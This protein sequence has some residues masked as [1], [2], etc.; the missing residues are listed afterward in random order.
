MARK[1]LSR[2]AG[3]VLRPTARTERYMKTSTVLAIFGVP[4]LFGVACVSVSDEDTALARRPAPFNLTD[5][6][7]TLDAD[8]QNYQWLSPKYDKGIYASSADTAPFKGNP[9]T[10]QNMAP[11][12]EKTSK[13]SKRK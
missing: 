12:I 4:L 11:R 10:Q 1:L 8:G 2:S 7:G 13:R 5:A 3:R 9:F 6:D